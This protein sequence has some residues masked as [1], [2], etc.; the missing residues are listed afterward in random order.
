MPK[1]DIIYFLSDQHHFAKSGFMGDACAVTPNF[2]SLAQNGVTLDACY[3]NSPLCVPSRSSLLTSLMPTRTGILNNMQMLPSDR[4]TVAH[5]LANAGYETVLAGRM[6]FSGYDQRHGFEKRLTGDITASF[7]G[8]D[9]EQRIYDFLKGTS[10]Q[11]RI[12][13]ELSGKGSSAVLKYDEGVTRDACNFLRERKDDRPLFLLVGTY[14]PHCPYI[15]YSAWYDYYYEQLPPLKPARAEYD[16]LHPA[17]RRWIDLRGVGDVTEEELRRVRAAYYAMITFTDENFG[18]VLEAARQTL[19]MSNTVVM[20]GSDHGDNAG[21][22][23][24]FWK[25][26]F[27]EGSSRIPMVYSWDGVFKKGARLK[28]PTS[29]LSLAPT[30]IEIAGAEP[31]PEMDGVSLLPSLKTGTEPDPLPVISVLGDIKG[32]NPSAMIRSGDY[33]LVLHYG[34]ET[35]QLFN[36][37]EDPGELHD[38]GNSGPHKKIITDLKN[39]VRRYWNADEA[40]R[41]LQVSIHQYKMLKAWIEKVGWTPLEEWITKPGDNFLER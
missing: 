1:P 3:C 36:L 30:L 12:A 7:P 39:E 23:G 6:H 17:I 20:Y 8:V 26:N 13:L 19:D 31:L 2:D 29:L 35:P 33:K 15:G 21:E 22:H 11:A 14:A 16:S 41:R 34:C 10:Y 18:K 28:T 25:T 5:S 37:R 27:Y 40:W 24:L 9:N 38:L 4:V 32:D